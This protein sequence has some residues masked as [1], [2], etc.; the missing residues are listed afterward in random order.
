[1]IEPLRYGYVD[2]LRVFACTFA[3]GDERTRLGF[4]VVTVD[5]GGRGESALIADCRGKFMEWSD[6]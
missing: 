1:M 3:T 4:R 6:G 5:A 2:G